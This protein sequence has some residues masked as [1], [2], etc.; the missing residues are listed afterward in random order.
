MG[1]SDVEAFRSSL[2]VYERVA[3]APQNQA[4]SAVVPVH[5]WGNTRA[6][7]RGRPALGRVSAGK[8][9]ALPGGM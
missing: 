9:P 2:A 8:L 6:C 1:V 5:S 7:E 3:A 4:R